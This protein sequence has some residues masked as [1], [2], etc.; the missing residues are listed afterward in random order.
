M[1]LELSPGRDRVVDVALRG[2]LFTTMTSTGFTAEDSPY[3]V[4]VRGPLEG[5]GSVEV[6]VHGLAKLQ[7]RDVSIEGKVAAL[8]CDE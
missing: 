6:E 7:S 1:T 2:Q 4:T 3:R 5:T 8:R